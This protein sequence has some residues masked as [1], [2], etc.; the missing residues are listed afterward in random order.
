MS[1]TQK[2]ILIKGVPDLTGAPLSVIKKEKIMKIKNIIKRGVAAALAAAIGAST[3]ATSASAATTGVN[4]GYMWNSNV[5]PTI[6]TRKEAV[7]GG[8][9][10]QFVKYGEQICRFVPSTGG[11]WVFCIEPG[12]S[13]QG[14]N[15][16]TWYTQY[17]FTKYDTFNVSDKNAAD[18]LS[19]WES[20]GGTDGP[21]A[22]YMG[23]V[24]YYGYSS[25]KTGDYFAAT[26]LLI[27]ELVL[28]YRGHTATTFGSCS[29]ILWNDF[30]YP[31]GGWCTKAGVEKAYNE[32]VANVKNHYSRPS[33]LKSSVSIAKEDPALIMKYNTTN[34]RYQ[35]SFSVPS[36]Y[37]NANSLTHNFSTLESKLTSLVKSKFSGTFGKDYGIDKST[38]GDNTTF[39]VWSKERQFTTNIYTTEEIA[40]QLKK[41][42][43][44]QETLFAKSYYQTC[45]L[46]TKLDPVSGYIGL[47]AYNEPNLVVE[48]TFTDS[49]NNAITGTELNTL[50]GKT[51]FT[52]STMLNGTKQYAVATYNSD[53]NYYVFS[54]YTTSVSEATKFKTLN[55][56]ATKGT[57]TLYDLPTSASS[58]RTYTVAEYSVPDADRYEKLSKDV[59]LPSPTS[60]FGANAGTKTVKMNNNETTFDAKVG[61]AELDKIV[62]NGDG[63]ALSTD[64]ESDIKT[65]ADI[66]KSTKFIVGYWDGKTVRYL[67]NDYLSAKSAF[68]GDLADLDNFTDVTYKFGDGM[69]YVPTTL[70]KDH[71]V[72][73][74][75]SRTTTDMSKAY[76]FSTGYN[77][78]GSDTCDYF[79]EIF[80]NLLPLDSSNNTQEIFFIEV[81]GYKGYGY[82]ESLDTANAYS[83]SSLGSAS[84]KR[85]IK[86]L[87]KNDTG[88]SINVTSGSAKYVVGSGKYYPISANKLESNR[89]HS[90]AEIVNQLT[91][92]ELVLTKKD[93]ANTV[94]S[95]AKY[96]LYNSS[97]KLLKTG[98]TGTDG[99]LK[100]DYDLLPNTDYY[101]KE[102]TPPAGYV[103]DDSYYKIN[104]SNSV[105]NDTDTF[106]NAKLTDYG[107]EVK[108]KPFELKIEVN[109]YDVINDVKVEGIVFDVTLNGKSVGTMKTDKNGY[110]CIEH[111]PLGKLNGKTFENVYV[112]TEKKNDKY[113]MIDEDGEVSRSITITTTTDDIES[114]TNPVITYTCDVPNTLQT[115]DLTVHKVD[116][117]GNPIKGATFDIYPTADVVF[118]GKTIQNAGVKLG[119]LTTD[120]NGNASTSY[121]E[122][123]SDGTQGYSKKIAIYPDNEY[124]LKETSVPAPFVLPKNNVTKFTADS[125]SNNTLT[126]P[127]EV[128]VPNTHQKGKLFVYKQDGDTK[129]ALTG[130]EFEVKA[131]ED[132]YF[133][134]T[135]I[136]SKGDLICTMTSG[137]DGWANSGKAVMYAGAK[138]TLTEI[139]A[140]EGYVL[141][142]D[143]KTFEFSFAGNEAEYSKLNVDF[144][145]TTQ[146][147][148]ITVHKTGEIFQSVATS[149]M[150]VNEKEYSIYA[151]GF[152]TGSLKGAVFEIKA[153][154]DIVTADGTV[155]V[156]A[157]EVV[158]TVTTDK[159]GNAVTKLL[160]LGKY[161]VTE[162]KAA[163]G[164]VINRKPQT[165]ELT[166]AGQ[167][168]EVRDTV[169]T[170]F[171]NKYQGVSIHL[172]KYMEHD[173]QYGVGDD[174]AAKNVVFGLYAEENIQAA[175]G[176]VIPANGLVSVIGI[177]EDMTAKFTDKLPFG[178]YYVQEISTDDKYVISGEKHIVTFEYA[179]QDAKT[180][181]IDGGKFDNE[182]KRGS[183]I[184]IKVDKHDN[185]LAN[186]VFGIFK[187]NC[188]SFTAKNAIAAAVSDEN[189]NF[190]I[191]EIPYGSYIVTEIEAPAGYVFSDKKYDVVIDEDGDKIEIRAENDEIKLHISKKDVYGNELAGA[192]MQLISADG[193]IFEEWVS[194]STEHTV[195]KLPAGRYTLHEVAAPNG[196]VITTD[197][198]FSIDRLNNVTV[199]GVNA[200]AVDE[201]GIPT[202]VMVDDT[203]KVEFSKT[204]FIAENKNDKSA[205]P[206]ELIGATMQ[207][208]DKD[209]KIVEE[210]VTTAEKHFIEAKLTAGET[211]TLHEA[212]AP[213]GYVLAEDIKFKVSA[214]GSV[215]RVRMMDDTT[216]VEISKTAVIA[217]KKPEIKS[218]SEF[219]TDKDAQE[220]HDLLLKIGF[221]PERIHQIYLDKLAGKVNQE[222]LENA[223]VGMPIDLADI[224]KLLEM[225]SDGKVHALSLAYKEYIQYVEEASKPDEAVPDELVGAVLQIIDKDGKVIDEWTTT[226]EKRYLEGILTAGET[227]TLHEVSA[228]DGYVL[229]DDI[230]FTVSE[231]GS[232][233]SINMVDDTT[234]VHITKTDIS[235]DNEIPGASMKLYDED[236]N[237][238]DEWVSTDTAHEIV[239]KL[240]A[241][242]KY[243]L[244]EESAPDGYVVAADIEFTVSE[245][246][247]IDAITMKDDTT[248]V[249]ISKRDIT[250]NDELPGATLQII[251]E[252]GEIVEEWVSTN[253]P[254]Y[255]EGKLIAGKEYILREI[256]APNGYE[257]AN[258][259]RFT[260][261]ENGN[262]TEVVM[263]DTPTPETPPSKPPKTGA[264]AND[265]GVGFALAALAIGAILLIAT[266]KKVK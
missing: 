147:G 244:H 193:S 31:A 145:N 57:F 26:Q 132:F 104:R 133:G 175:D 192:K 4:I 149:V 151:P 148:T 42:L 136:H 150:T 105:V 161:E 72:I 68:N 29:D 21:L 78:S 36:S 202:I 239:G 188:K 198:S 49:H 180:V 18:S 103:L 54:R 215:D 95:G 252:N 20:L 178:R 66:Y 120:E 81:N 146:Q 67:S 185:P 247:E 232:V 206:D 237:L 196:Y 243:I 34:M 41:G 93:D 201:N 183:V 233:D 170:S 85:S 205:V 74:D 59:T 77:Y 189:G 56:G 139:K 50:L 62:R 213:A 97:K 209:G 110:A 266:R 214:N 14:S 227:Y 16:G 46:S 47:A 113:I 80:L 158:D 194:D 25:H 134:K 229:A 38:S 173:E 126:I 265:S 224:A 73:F 51:T 190:R 106:S 155:R 7:S 174:F 164:Y 159:N 52:V 261:D 112:I 86:G 13:M 241:G 186:A 231:D 248:K 177:G 176:S 122:Y 123:E 58:G 260:V 212:A 221:T 182:I 138:Y 218:F 200:V 167:E 111:L 114:N 23:L 129:R 242:K 238:I 246:G 235:G 216:K 119:T 2:N 199:D 6:Y 264:E 128:T 87:V 90:D 154:D 217:E 169:K 32:I 43:T 191:D 124:A 157:G 152:A 153:V 228:P 165:V 262:V 8:V 258:D 263:Y 1:S 162:I 107:Y 76:V 171:T 71:K 65:L 33:V 240:I 101:V 253:E 10:G 184:G 208:I 219:N 135:K 220:V 3:L 131:A 116:E 197:I 28:G 254:R 236:G 60:D 9:S 84:N 160:Y 168:A 226:S 156:K 143:S 222:Y 55:N 83:L 127:H 17:G 12:K 63:K 37:L 39:T 27:W 70:N 109:K 61:T 259:V 163:L 102:I 5:N 249:K 250:T 256:T 40:M 210:W 118:N 115:V 187:T 19:Y 207:I 82:D 53:K 35:A 30:T 24:Q 223:I 225:K 255:I 204:A 117:A 121:V 140:V 245:T 45:L 75:S 251:D 166:Y 15:S 48:K 96:G 44:K 79:G 100:F 144:D 257:V 69:Y 94:L 181:D 141:K 22:K 98:F 130:A 64:N 230:Q 108:D 99:K 92:Y 88:S 89:L 91:S 137:T 203:T 211:Y 11:D 142:K 195:T 125:E 179:G 234:K 172:T